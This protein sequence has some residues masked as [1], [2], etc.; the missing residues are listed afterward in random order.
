MKKEIIIGQNRSTSLQTILHY[1]SNDQYAI[2]IA[3]NFDAVVRLESE[4]PSDY[5]ILSAELLPKAITPTLSRL[6]ALSPQSQLILTH[7]DSLLIKKQL[8]GLFPG[9]QMFDSHLEDEL[10]KEMIELLESKDERPTLGAFLADYIPH[11]G[12]ISQL[13]PSWL[14]F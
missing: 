8:S 6:E 7:T 2:R 5:L 9:I 1:F 10:P 4:K 14:L 11:K 12:V 13:V 3:P